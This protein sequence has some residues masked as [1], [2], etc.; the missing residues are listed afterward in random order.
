MAVSDVCFFAWNVNSYISRAPYFSF[1]KISKNSQL[2]NGNIWYFNFSLNYYLVGYPL[3][4]TTIFKHLEMNFLNFLYQCSS[5]L[6]SLSRCQ[7][8]AHIS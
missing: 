8:E 4:S 3:A 7:T 2:M 5:I 1:G 6:P